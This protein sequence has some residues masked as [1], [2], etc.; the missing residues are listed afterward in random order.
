M[1]NLNTSKVNVEAGTI[2]AQEILQHIKILASDEFAGRCPATAGEELTLQY[3][4]EHFNKLTAESGVTFETHRQ[5]VPAIE[6]H[7][8]SGL[9]FSDG[10]IETQLKGGQDFVASSKKIKEQVKIEQSQVVFAGY[11]IV[12]P[13]YGWDDF[14]GLNVEGKTL[15]VLTG[16]PIL[17]HPTKPQ[18]IDDTMFRGSDLTYYGRWTYKYEI[19]GAK[20]AAAVFIIHETQRAGY[21]WDVVAHSFGHEEFVLASANPNQRADIEGWLTYEQGVQLLEMSGQN[22]EQLKKSAQSKDFKPVELE[23]TATASVTS[24]FKNVDSHNFVAVMPGAD[25]SVSTES[26]LYSAHW[27]H[28]GTNEK[29]VLSGA[30]DNGTGVAGVLALATAFAKMQTKF[31]RSVVFFIPTLEEQNLLGTKFYVEN[32]LLPIAETL[33]VLNLEMLCPWGPS[34]SLSSVCRGHST[35]D[36]MLE[37]AT[38]KRGRSVVG[39]PQPEKGYLYRSDHLPFMQAGVPALALFFS[40]M[41]YLDKRQQFIVEDYHK[42][43]DKPRDDW[44][45][46]GAAQ[47]IELFLEIGCELLQSGYRATW[48]DMSEFRSKSAL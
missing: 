32:A 5:K 37:E 47:D 35:L 48:N 31:P 22:F 8:K 42:V 40:C 30:I 28:F 26:I 43:T 1:T 16:D 27:D 3:F 10:T 44:N 2:S 19:A 24:T 38:R 18:K 15:L 4:E 39:D 13:E 21:G 17:P 6:I 45:L 11:G 12:A 25:K 29:G 23:L 7:S 20:K 33:A 41:D 46:S 36:Q 14:K 9:G 34:K